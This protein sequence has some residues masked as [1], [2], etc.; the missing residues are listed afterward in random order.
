MISTYQPWDTSII[1]SYL[2]F[3]TWQFEFIYD[4]NT[5]KT[6]FW[7]SEKISEWNV[8]PITGPLSTKRR[9]S[10]SSEHQI[11]KIKNTPS[12]LFCYSSHCDLQFCYI[13]IFLL[14]CQI[15]SNLI[16]EIIIL[17]HFI[18]IFFHPLVFV[19]FV[20][21]P[22]INIANILLYTY[23]QIKVTKKVVA[24]DSTCFLQ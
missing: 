14:W 8:E 6:C 22:K 16:H 23:I 12:V 19:S 18:R 7:T 3:N 11:D 4:L 10:S 9:L 17:L 5:L 24:I 21:K 15:L 20:Y 13:S 1:H 2:E